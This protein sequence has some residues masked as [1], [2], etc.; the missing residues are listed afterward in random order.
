MT[1]GNVVPSV[2]KARSGLEEQDKQCS[3]MT[4]G[5]DQG[6]EGIHVYE[7]ITHSFQLDE[8]LKRE[9]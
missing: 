2:L 8:D 7:P 4:A 1:T 5:N 6:G 3:A 9:K